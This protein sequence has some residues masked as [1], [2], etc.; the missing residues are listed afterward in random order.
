MTE[1]EKCEAKARQAIIRAEKRRRATLGLP[2]EL[3]PWEL[4][5]LGLEP[6][7]CYKTRQRLASGARLAQHN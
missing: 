6:V 7:A 5:R 3:T 4:D 2:L 1:A